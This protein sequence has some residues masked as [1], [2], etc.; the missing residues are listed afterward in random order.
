MDEECFKN[1]CSMRDTPSMNAG[2]DTTDAKLSSVLPHASIPG[3][4]WE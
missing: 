3:S 2:I 4:V 1:V